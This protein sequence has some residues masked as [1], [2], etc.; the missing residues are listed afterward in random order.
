MMNGKTAGGKKLIYICAPLKGDIAGNIAKARGYCKTVLSMGYI[1]IAPHV[2]LD[3]V[4]NDNIPHERNTAL[5]MGTELLTICSELWVFSS[6]TSDRMQ[7]EINLAKQIGI[8]VKRVCF[9]FE[10]EATQG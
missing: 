4:L 8:P 6:I 10:R 3:G 7:A 1:P 9:D 2:M 5:K